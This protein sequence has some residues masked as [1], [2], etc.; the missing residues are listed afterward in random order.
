MKRAIIF[1][2]TQGSPE[3]NWFRWLEFDLQAKGY[4]VWL[5]T[6]PYAEQPSLME[7][8]SFVRSHCPFPLDENVMIV[9]HS[10]GAILAFVLLQLGYTF[11]GVAA[12]SIFMDNT[13]GWA[14]NDKLFDVEFDYAALRA[15]QT[16]RVIINSDTDPY[17]PLAQAETIA[18][19][20]G[21]ELLVLKDQGHFNLE[22]SPTYAEFPALLAAMRER[23]LLQEAA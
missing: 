3:G 11:A 13:L 1:H 15:N 2:G 6:L 18:E 4:D 20:S 21:T 8:A 12:V 10:S 9:G 7:W 19:Q 23:E 22:R 5:P 16:P 17:V 14:P